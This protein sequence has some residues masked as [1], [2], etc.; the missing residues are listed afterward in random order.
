M[1]PLLLLLLHNNVNKYLTPSGSLWKKN[2]LI[3]NPGTSPHV[4]ESSTV[5]PKVWMFKLLCQKPCCSG[6]QGDACLPPASP[7]DPVQMIHASGF[8]NCLVILPTILVTFLTAPHQSFLAH[9]QPCS[10]K[11]SGKTGSGH[12]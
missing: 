7:V 3:L 1:A 10:S 12:Y 9:L 6:A 8:L 2:A 4:S 11:L 5:H